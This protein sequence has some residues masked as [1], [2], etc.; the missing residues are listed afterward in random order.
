MSFNICV[1]LCNLW[2]KKNRG[3]SLI[4]VNLCNLWLNILCGLFCCSSVALAGIIPESSDMRL[5]EYADSLELWSPEGTTLWVDSLLEGDSIVVEYDAMVVVADSS[6]R[7]SDLNCFFMASEPSG[8]STLAG[9][10]EREGIF[11]RCY[12]MQLYYVGYG[13]NYNSTTRMR[14]YTGRGVPPI[15]G[16]YTDAAHL[17]LPNRWYHIRLSLLRGT[18]R[19]EMDGTTL[20]TYVDPQ[21]LRR[22]HFG[23]RTTKAHV[24]L[25]GI[26]IAGMR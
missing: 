8:R 7:L 13:G 24:K 5:V 16:E 14:R 10:E 12:A 3:L 20:F 22:G 19:Y 6:D 25:R 23:F 17:L 15:E 26:R 4:R 11:A 2:L 9:I 1:N 21:P 18:F